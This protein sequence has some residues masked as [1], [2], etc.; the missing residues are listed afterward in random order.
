MHLFSLPAFSFNIVRNDIF[1]VADNPT[2]TFTTT[3]STLS[4]KA[5]KIDSFNIQ[6]YIQKN[7]KLY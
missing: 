7:M 1:T 3:Q 5:R 2:Q 4:G 6:S